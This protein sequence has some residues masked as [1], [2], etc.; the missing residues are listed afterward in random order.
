ML[1]SSHTLPERQGVLQAP[2]LAS[3]T[4]DALAAP[5]REAAC[6]LCPDI[7]GIQSFDGARNKV[8]SFPALGIPAP[9]VGFAAPL[10]GH[11]VGLLPE[12]M[13][14]QRAVRTFLL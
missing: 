2:G 4:F 5:R 6:C 13:R 9:F 12:F 14:P 8:F 1:S 7:V 11:R 3:N 10:F